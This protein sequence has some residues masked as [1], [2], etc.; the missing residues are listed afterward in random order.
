MAV[1]V[2]PFIAGA[3]VALGVE[4]SSSAQVPAKAD[5]A[6]RNESGPVVESGSGGVRLLGGTVCLPGTGMFFYSGPPER[7]EAV[8]DRGSEDSPAIEPAS[9]STPE[10]PQSGAAESDAGAGVR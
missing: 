1:R 2:V 9:Q 3:V 6:I 5:T 10:P 8:K 4:V 7:H